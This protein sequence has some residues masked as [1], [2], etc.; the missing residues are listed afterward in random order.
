MFSQ[1]LANPDYDQFVTRNP[2]VA[3]QQSLIGSVPPAFFFT[4]FGP[5]DATNVAAITPNQWTNA[6]RQS[7]DGVDLFGSY[8]TELAGGMLTASG[9]ASWLQGTQQS[10]LTSAPFATVGTVFN[11]PHWR[12]RGGLLW[13]RDGF[14]MAANV[15][16]VGGELDNRST[17][18]PRVAS[19]TTNRRRARLQIFQPLAVRPRT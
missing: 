11:S 18:N 7:Y 3:Q 4:Y 17:P 15:N 9:S 5:Y 12:G 6:A 8:S 14:S 13:K 10:S 1:A 19:Q 2:S 16:Y